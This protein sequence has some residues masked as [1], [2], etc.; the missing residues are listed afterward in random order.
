MALVGLLVSEFQI[1]GPRDDIAKQVIRV[2]LF[3]IIKL[4]LL[5]LVSYLCFMHWNLVWKLFGMVSLCTL[6]PKCD[7]ANW[8]R[9]LTWVFSCTFAAYFQNTFSRNTS[10]C[11]LLI[12][13]E[14][15]VKML[16]SSVVSID[17]VFYMGSPSSQAP[18][19]TLDF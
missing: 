9:T 7:F 5:C 6:M 12:I 16:S 18:F 17:H 4:S 19:T 3:G 11:V 1:R 2:F 14:I 15:D 10:W 13:I 8:N